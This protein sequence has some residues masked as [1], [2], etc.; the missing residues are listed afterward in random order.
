MLGEFVRQ[1]QLEDVFFTGK[2]TDS[3]LAAYYHVADLLLCMSEHEGFNVPLVEA[4]HADVPI[5]AYNSTSIPYTLG[6]AGVVINKK[7]YEE[8]AEM[9]DVLIE[10]QTVRSQIL[11]AQQQQLAYFQKPRLEQI[12]KSYIEQVIK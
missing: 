10:N 4:M 9:M 2:I 6:N 12:L 11:S 7:C 5:L 8:I 3:E 1:L